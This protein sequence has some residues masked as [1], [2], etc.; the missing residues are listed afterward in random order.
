MLLE[1][2][3]E[4]TTLNHCLDQAKTGRGSVVLVS[5][6]AGV[7]KTSLLRAFAD[8]H[9]EAKIC[10]GMCDAL[11][12]P[13]TLGPIYDISIALC[14]KTRALAEN[15]ANSTALFPA[16]LSELSEPV[17]R[18]LVIE[19]IHWA[20]F[21]TLDFVKYIA[22]RIPVLNTVLIA[23]FR[24][25]EVDHTHPVQ[26]VFGDLQ[27]RQITRI[28]ISP[29]SR[30]AV[31][32]LNTSAVYDT[33]HLM[34]VTGGNPFF[35]SELLAFPSED[36]RSVPIS[37]KE[38]VNAR[39][40]RLT[41]AEREF[42]E[43][44]S[45][46]PGAIDM[47]II[48][49]CM[50]DAEMLAMACV[51]RNILKFDA[52]GAL[53]FR[54]EL[55]RLATLSRLSS[56]KLRRLHAA[57]L[58]QLTKGSAI[59]FASQIVHHAEGAGDAKAVLKYAPSAAEQAATA[60]SHREAAAHLATAL[61]FVDDAEPE[62]AALLYEK[63]AYEAGLSLRIDEDVIEA[64]RHA[65]TLW[66]ALGRTEKV[67]DNLRWLS[68]LLWY[69]GEAVQA[70]R[71]ADEAVRI[72]ENESPSREKALA[73]SLRSQIHMLNGR[74]DDAILW[75]K[76]ALKAAGKIDGPDIQAHALNNIGTAKIFRGDRGGLG[77]LEK[78]LS[79]AKAHDLHEDAARV[80]T[81]LAEYAVEFREFDLAERVLSEGIAFDTKHDLDSWTFYLVGRLAQLRL[82]EGRFDEAIA[83]AKSVLSRQDQTLLMRLPAQIVLA[84][85]QLRI[86][87]DNAQSSLDEALERA[88][89]TDEIQY[90]APLRIACIEQAWLNN[91]HDIAAT[92]IHAM[93]PDLAQTVSEWVYGEF[94]FWSAKCGHNVALPQEKKL[95]PPYATYFEGD[96][97][98]AAQLFMSLGSNYLAAALLSE[99]K[100]EESLKSGYALSR[101][102]QAAPLMAKIRAAAL[103]AGFDAKH[104]K[105]QRGPY[106]AARSHPL[107]L[108]KKEQEILAMIVD[109]ADNQ[110]I[111][112]QMS[113]SKRTIEH[114]VSSI[115]SKL[116]ASNRIDVLLRVQ[117]EPWILGRQ[118]S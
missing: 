10:W 7:G 63:W 22:R 11:Y 52:D 18:V 86:G 118:A 66:R 64:R 21:A 90:I 2:D 70:N 111:A 85:A 110:E 108:T 58:A 54:H 15:G 96:A 14:E 20:D 13:Q 68:R 1:R 57:L 87:D 84:K 88:L 72:L 40:N 4:L 19:D 44:V 98:K 102:I 38:T 100:S 3:N 29:L 94:L 105:T 56:G 71:Y 37:I 30:S 39:L 26:A 46:I 116:N 104:F 79:L 76:K 91:R 75:G 80:Y 67:G 82:E 32:T 35:L 55:A 27:S 53:R 69:Q 49:R 50:P 8:Q 33:N 45:I 59:R 117:N 101:Q 99:E 25:D 60:G 41:E 113:R 83:I 103:A 78:S 47:E 24:D 23:S 62:Q 77:D 106:H 95:P 42:V 28:K 93:A 51:G 36:M 81:N 74:M 43:F 109:G 89:Q 61:K 16:L 31:E 97:T 6:E 12:T 107:G 5:G 9:S 92:H 112:D 115:F 48:A 114:H 17:P 73:F 34:K 65:I